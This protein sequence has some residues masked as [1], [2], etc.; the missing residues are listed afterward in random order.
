MKPN[1]K[2]DLLVAG[3]AVGLVALWAFATGAAAAPA[4]FVPVTVS[5]GM[6]ELAFNPSGQFAFSLR[7]GGVWVSASILRSGT[8]APSA[9]PLPSSGPLLVSAALSGSL[10]SLVWTLNGTQWTSVYTVQ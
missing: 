1:E 3:V 7:P 5:S 6:Q 9:L 4:G 2:R 10:V 8:V